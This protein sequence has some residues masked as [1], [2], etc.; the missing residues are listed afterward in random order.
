MRRGGLMVSAHNSG[1]YSG[2][3]TRVDALCSW[4]R[5]FSLFTA[6]NKCVLTNLML[7]VTL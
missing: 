6:V 3:L 5:H 2:V 4:A 1:S 7:T